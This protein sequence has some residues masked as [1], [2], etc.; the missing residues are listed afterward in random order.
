LAGAFFRVWAGVTIGSFSLLYSNQYNKPELFAA[1]YA[2]IGFIGGIFSN[3]FYAI[4]CDRYE[5]RFIR[6]KSYAAAG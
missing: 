1:I 5:H 6:I 4:L 2:V 3:M